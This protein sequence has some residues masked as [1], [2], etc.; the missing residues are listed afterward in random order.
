MFRGEVA[1]LRDAEKDKV[2][3]TVNVMWSEVPAKPYPATAGRR[4]ETL[5]II[6][7]AIGRN[8]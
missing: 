7:R 1:S 5:I 4:L 6:F 3:P 2:D 8:D